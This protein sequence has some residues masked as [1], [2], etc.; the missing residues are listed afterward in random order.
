MTRSIILTYFSGSGILASG[1]F[2]V[3]LVGDNIK[4]SREEINDRWARSSQIA[5]N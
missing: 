1:G 4:L 3:F 5:V 2:S